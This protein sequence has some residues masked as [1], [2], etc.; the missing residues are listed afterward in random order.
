MNS[1]N[2][3]AQLTARYP[4]VCNNYGRP[5]IK[6]KKEVSSC[7]ILELSS[8]FEIVERRKKKRSKTAG[9]TK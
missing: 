9:S 3:I 1:L 2:T 4:C 7:H 5:L 6:E 8:I